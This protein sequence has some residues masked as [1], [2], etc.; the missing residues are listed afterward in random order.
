M[1][2][3]YTFK[4]TD[5]RVIKKAY[6]YSE[7]EPKAYINCKNKVKIFQKTNLGFWKFYRTNWTNFIIFKFWGFS[8]DFAINFLNIS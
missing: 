5:S 8:S 7:L 6:N 1:L 3:V 4:S 2:I